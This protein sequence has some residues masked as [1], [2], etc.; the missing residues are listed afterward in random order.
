VNLS[1]LVP[2]PLPQD[3]RRFY[4]TGTGPRQRNAR[5]NNQDRTE[6]LRNKSFVVWDGEGAHSG[7]RKAQ[8]YILFGYYD[9]DEHSFIDGRSLTTYA[10]LRHIIQAGERYKNHWHVGFAFDYDVNM[11]L[12]NL[13][14]PQ[15]RRL[16]ETGSCLLGDHEYR[17]EHIP[18]KWFRVTHYRQ[19]KNVTVTIYD[20]WGFFQ[21]SFVK[22]LKANIPDHELMVHLPEIEAGKDK[23]SEFTFAQF[24]FIKQYWEI[25]SVLFHAL[26]NQLRD[27]LY[28]AELFIAKWH[29]P[30]ELANYAYRTNGIRNHKS[31]F[32]SGIYDLA[33]YGYAGGRFE[34]FHIGRYQNAYA[35]DINSAYPF[36]ISHLPSLSEGRWEHVENVSHD[37][38]A[39]FGIYRVSLRQRL[40]QPAGPVFCRDRRGN[41]SYPWMVDGW[42]WS[43]EI[44]AM[45]A[46][47]PH[48]ESSVLEGWEYVGWE[49]RP[50]EFVADV[51]RE[52]RRMKAAGIG[53]QI[54]L[55]L[56]LNS[57]YGKMAQR[58][59]WK[60][61]GSAPAWHQLEWAG[62]VTSFTRA[63]LYTVMASLKYDELIAV[64]TDGLFST[65]EPEKIGLKDS[66]ELGGWEVTPIDELIYLQSGFYS[67]RVGNQWSL[68]YRGL[69]STSVSIDA[70]IQHSKELGPIRAPR[71]T[72]ND[73]DWPKLTGTTTRFIGYQNALWRAS[74]RDSEGLSVPFEKNHRVWETSDKEFD[75]GGGMKRV[76]SPHMCRACD[77]GVSAYDMPHDTVI[78]PQAMARISAGIMGVDYASYP[79]D[80]PWLDPDQSTWRD[81]LAETEGLLV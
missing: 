23:R 71:H 26:V 56:L 22:A 18:G 59:G 77:A 43:P 25:E 5:L 69:D 2:E 34:R 75:T 13:T 62:W 44:K 48:L 65:L 45:L 55:K 21:S 27:Y 73:P 35:Y 81:Y 74:H 37:R 30:G 47:N 8:D 15:F 29:G 14:V 4:H 7:V 66:S 57:L 78:R 51:Y 64:E 63:Q 46:A 3:E 53:T 31:D 49:T 40:G 6:Y 52:R 58:A 17:I 72:W 10:C 80:I 33:R 68:K 79:H 41:I 1:D 61:T 12:R 50:F 9:G 36:A 76:H 38:I 19:P 32:G 67:K 54:A 20:V 42:Y 24:E 60:R 39:E 11:I 70:I 16:R 28:D